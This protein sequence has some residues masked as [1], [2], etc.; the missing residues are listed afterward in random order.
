VSVLVVT[1]DVARHCGAIF[2]EL[3]KAGTPVPVNDRS[4]LTA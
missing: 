4:V 2:A 3:R 1:P